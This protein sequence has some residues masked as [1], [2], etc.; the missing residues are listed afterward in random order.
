MDNKVEGAAGGSQSIQAVQ[1]SLQVRESSHSSTGGLSRA[2]SGAAGIQFVASAESGTASRNAP[3]VDAIASFTSMQQ[4]KEQSNQVAQSVRQLEGVRDGID[5]V[6]ENLTKIV[7]M[8]PPYPK[9]SSQ[10]AQL[11]NDA[12]GMRKLIEQLTIPPA[13]ETLVRN[14]LDT[15]ALSDV[16]ADDTQVSVALDRLNVA[17]AAIAAERKKLFRS[18][19]ASGVSDVG[20]ELAAQQQSQS[21]GAGLAATGQGVSSNAAKSIAITLT[22]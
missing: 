7:K 13:Y 6:A 1:S 8:Y 17:S 22:E 21:A 15:P 11:L 14:A 12:Y 4:T 9:D 19:D 10:R 20:A 3:S 18:G 16:N 5:K 2:G